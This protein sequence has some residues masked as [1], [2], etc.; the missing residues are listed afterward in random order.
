MWISTGTSLGGY[1][2]TSN[3]DV[4]SESFGCSTWVSP[5]KIPSANTITAEIMVSLFV[6]NEISTCGC[7]NMKSKFKN[8]FKS[9]V[10]G[11]FTY[12]NIGANDKTVYLHVHLIIKKEI[13]SF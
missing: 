8:L 10:P 12:I 1:R 11:V 13:E 2:A 5:S 4:T 7:E 3:L 6:D 9:G